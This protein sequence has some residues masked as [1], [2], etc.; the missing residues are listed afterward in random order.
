[1][2][3]EIVTRG[4]MRTNVVSA[5]LDLPFRSPTNSLPGHVPGK[6]Q[7]LV[8][9]KTVWSVEDVARELSVS[10]RQVY[11]L[12]SKDQIPYSKVGRLVRFSPARIS[13]WLQKGGTR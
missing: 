4:H 12:I 3:T 8:F 10:V 5:G 1:M 2:K 7:D 6:P 13:E 11:R 9:E